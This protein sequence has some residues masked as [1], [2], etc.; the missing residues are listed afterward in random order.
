MTLA[1][2]VSRQVYRRLG[3][4]PSLVRRFC[5][6]G[7]SDDSIKK[8]AVARYIPGR[9]KRRLKARGLT[10]DDLEITQ[11]T[12]PSKSV[13]V[14][15]ALRDS[16]VDKDIT[17]DFPSDITKDIERRQQEKH[18]HRPAGV[19]PQTTSIL[20]FP[21][22]GSQFVGMGKKLLAYPGVEEL[23]HNASKILGYDLLNI[24]IN[25]PIEK[26]NRTV[27]CQPAIVVTSLATLKKLQEEDPTA[28]ENCV[29]AAG[30]S[31]G[32]FTALVASEML[33][34][35]DAIYL[36]KLRAEAMQ[37]MS[38]RVD[39]GMMTV[40]T[41]HQS[42][43]RVAM[44]AAREYCSR[45]LKIQ[46][47]VCK[48]A[49]FL[50]TNVKVVAGHTEALDFLQQ[51]GREW[52]LNKMKRLPVSGAFHTQLMNDGSEEF[53]KYWRAWNNV[54]FNQSKFA[55]HSNVDGK[56]YIVGEEDHTRPFGKIIST[57]RRQM[58]EPVQWEQTMHILFS[59]RQGLTYPRV[60]E[61]GP[62]KQLGV[63]LKKTNSKAYEQYSHIDC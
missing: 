9:I 50:C 52:H 10:E 20:L 48:I 47:P 58:Y 40:M 53:Y 38:E 62:G 4:C 8:G 27:Y 33:S 39:S 12:K 37:K 44:V 15:Q 41:D 16:I 59:R 60:F 1:K 26:L 63:L 35:E 2:V 34:F 36:I 55:V 21:G 24:C 3:I 31:V 6:H 49:N 42:K 25:G 61:V 46:D 56:R 23:Y 13:D 54:S 22:Q 45:K 29:G 18:A 32:E 14:Q 51:Y 43:I 30:F 17:V 19:D 7:D 11:V 57:L 5:D 28:Y